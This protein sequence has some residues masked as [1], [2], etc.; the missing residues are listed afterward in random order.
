[1]NWPYANLGQGASGKRSWQ[2]GTPAP[3]QQFKY[4]FD[5]IGSR[6]TAGRGGDHECI[7]N[8]GTEPFAV[9]DQSFS[10]ATVAV[11]LLFSL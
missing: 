2:D 11:D 8:S 5:D 10:L 3:S 7:P 4:A 9:V 6:Q 1:M